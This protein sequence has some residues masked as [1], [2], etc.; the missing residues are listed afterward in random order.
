MYPSQA[1]RM[2]FRL[3]NL[4]LLPKELAS[5]ANAQ[6]QKH[7]DAIWEGCGTPEGDGISAWLGDFDAMG[8]ADEEFQRSRD[9]LMAGKVLYR[10]RVQQ[11]EMNWSGFSFLTYGRFCHYVG[12]LPLASLEKVPL[13][14]YEDWYEVCPKCLID[15]EFPDDEDGCKCNPTPFEEEHY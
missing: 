13:D 2:L 3:K 1:T 12:P 10:I 4:R 5:R 9:I 6:W 7:G 8:D 11:K 14:K 15:T